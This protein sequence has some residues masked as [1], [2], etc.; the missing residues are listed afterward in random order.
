MPALNQ[1]T[2]TSVWDAITPNL[3]D[4]FGDAAFKSWLS[5]LVFNGV[6]DG[7]LSLSAPSNFMKDWVVAHYE[8]SILRHSQASDITIKKL[9]LHVVSKNAKSATTDAGQ[10]K[11]TPDAKVSVIR[12]K[13]FFSEEDF[14]SS[15]DPRYTFDNFVVAKSNE[16]A[17][18]A[19]MRVTES[20]KPIYNPLFLHGGVGLGKT[21]LMHAIAWQIH[22]NHKKKRVVYLSAEKFMYS[23]IKALRLKDASSFKESLRNVDVL[24]IDDVQFIGGKDTTQEEFFHTFNALVDQQ[25]QVIISADKSPNDLEKI[26]D[27]LKSRLSWG[28][29]ADIHPTTY[30]LRLGI[31]QSKVEAMNMEVDP[32][33]LEFLAFKITSNVRELEGALNRIIA[34]ATLIGRTITIDTTQEVLRDVLR[35]N[36]RR[37][38]IDDIQRRVC[39][40]YQI[41]MS[42]M[43]SSKRTQN[44]TKPRH[45]AMYLSK[46]MTTKSLPEIGKNFGGK[47]HTSVLHSV[48]KITKLI[49]DDSDLMTE[50]NT[51]QESLR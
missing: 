22:K 36:E 44:I 40:F 5:P 23:F 31:L 18:A 46:N 16:L 30:E 43:L 47:D 8:Q 19:S 24:M 11:K 41:K 39:E 7:E 32:Q 50:I 12:N 14:I 3:I 45:V 21:H 10:N 20:D 15:L 38:T 28:L 34:H 49:Q 4:D 6:K 2:V 9:S 33:V 17:Y 27:R 35:S 26:G 48:R 1:Q 13:E 29:V 42:E 25:K 37:L 51:L